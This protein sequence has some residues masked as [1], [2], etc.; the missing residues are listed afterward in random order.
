MI[1]PRFTRH[2]AVL[3]ALTISSCTS[4]PPLQPGGVT[5][6]HKGKFDIPLNISN[7]IPAAQIRN[8]DIDPTGAASALASVLNH[9]LALNLQEDDALAILLQHGD[10]QRFIDTNGRI[11]LLDIA[12]ALHS[13]GLKTY[14]STTRWNDNYLA[15]SLEDR[16]FQKQLKLIKNP[17][18]KQFLP[19]IALL[20]PKKDERYF[21]VI[22]GVDDKYI[23]INDPHH[24]T[25]AMTE[26]ELM[27]YIP[28]V[29]LVLENTS[30]TSNTAQ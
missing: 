4:S 14:G 6:F 26:S 10:R 3:C 13:Y 29:M 22:Q 27:R 8:T 25:V 30:T 12:K 17:Q 21:V 15:A 24:G 7:P 1:A 11:T 16:Q 18:A 23:Y 19:I 5:L 20:V 28:V 9:K 2:L